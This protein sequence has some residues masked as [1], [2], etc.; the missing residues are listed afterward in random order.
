MIPGYALPPVE[1]FYM[2]DSVAT[3]A[4]QETQGRSLWHDAWRRITANRAAVAAF[5][6]LLVIL[7]LA[8]SGPMLSDHAF[9]EILVSLLLDI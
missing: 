8:I 3:I 1:E 4:E 5:A 9:D 7:L 6:V 2:T